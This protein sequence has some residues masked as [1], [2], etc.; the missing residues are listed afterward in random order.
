[1]KSMGFQVGFWGHTVMVGLGLGW[2]GTNVVLKIWR[3]KLWGW[4]EVLGY[5][6]FRVG[7]GVYGGSG[8]G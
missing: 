5:G 7:M 8:M 3:A 2:K 4:R 6:V 1:M